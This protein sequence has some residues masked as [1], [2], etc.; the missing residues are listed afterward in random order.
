MNFAQSTIFSI[1]SS[2]FLLFIN[3]LINVIESRMLGPSEIGR[4]QVF[5]TTQTFFST[6]CAL[7]IGQSCIYFINRLKFNERDILSTSVNATIPIATISSIVLFFILLLNPLY[8]GKEKIVYLAIFSIGTYAMLINNIFTPVLL[9]RMEVVRNQTVKWFTRIATL[10]ALLIALLYSG[11]LS[12][13][14]L[15]ALSGITNILATILLYSYLRNRFSFFDGINYS[16]LWRIL[17]WG[18]KFA[19]N[20]LASITLLSIPIYFLT[21]FSLDDGFLNVGYYSRANALLVVGTTIASSIGP[22]LYSKWSGVNQVD[23]KKQVR[24]ISFLYILINLFI[25]LGLIVFAHLIVFLLYGEHF[26]KAVP[27]LQILALSL[28]G[29]GCKEICYGI[30]SSQGYPLKIM[31][32]LVIGS[33]LCAICNYFV[34]PKFGVIGC[35]FI[36][37]FI[38]ILTALLLIYDVTHI[39]SVSFKDFFIIPTKQD[40]TSI[41][42]TIRKKK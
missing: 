24:K 15:I 7:G 3:L 40:F 39:S 35:S 13:S 4:Y 19:G 33:V 5:V 12:V 38:S 30:L 18:L 31:T 27:V 42:Q 22:L 16:L 10:L 6:I 20:N 9:T 32:N 25:A 17:K 14:F 2:F 34:I 1:V 36:T 28:L 11:S 41:I 37:T 29:S 21:W 26:M 23:L 8:F